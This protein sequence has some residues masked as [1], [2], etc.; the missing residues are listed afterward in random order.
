MEP[1]SGQTRELKKLRTG[2]AGSSHRVFVAAQG[3]EKL[4]LGGI[5]YQH[6]ILDGNDQV[7][8]V[9]A[10]AQVVNG[11]TLGLV[12]SLWHLPIQFVCVLQCVRLCSV[13]L[14]SFLDASLRLAVYV[15]LHQPESHTATGY[16]LFGC[17]I[18]KQRSAPMGHWFRNAHHMYKRAPSSS[19]SPSC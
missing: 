11:V 3:V 9:R 18:V 7:G 15:R 13:C 16:L 6:P 1:T 2:H 14:P 17:D 10:E 19:R 12:I 8:A 4:P 5:V